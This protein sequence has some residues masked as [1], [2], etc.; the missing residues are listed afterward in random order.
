MLVT[1]GF[2][3]LF[4]VLLI[5]VMVLLG[6]SALQA[7]LIVMA[8]SMAIYLPAATI[9]WPGA[10]V[11]AMHIAMYI[12]S[13]FV[14]GI[15]FHHRQ[16]AIAEGRSTQLH[17]EPAIILG[18][19]AVLV[20]VNAIFVTVAQ[21]GLSAVGWVLPE[22]RMARGDI[23]HRFPGTVS[24]DFHKKESLYNEYL[25]QVIAQRERGWQIRRGFLSDAIAN[26]PIVF[27]VEARDRDDALI[28][29]ATVNAQF[30]R[31]AN[32]ED[33]QEFALSQVSPG[34]YEVTLTLPY[35]GR[36]DLVLT[37]EKEKESEVARHEVRGHTIVASR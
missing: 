1:L 29:D 12:M 33:D 19:F 22:G 16:K 27:R 17:R 36:W 13:A 9:F 37:V 15:I 20:V 4:I 18:F 26:Q 14:C 2:G 28:A 8:L 25:Q 23:S 32:A 21:G 10:D 5:S 30:L 34:V 24:H 11:L 3:S 35:P 31:S 6:M 7:T